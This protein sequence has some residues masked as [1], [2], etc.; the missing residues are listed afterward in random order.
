MG[1]SIISLAGGNKLALGALA[2]REDAV[3]QSGQLP[4][5]DLQ[6]VVDPLFVEAQSADGVRGQP[7]VDQLVGG[8]GAVPQLSVQ[9]RSSTLDA[10]LEVERLVE[11]LA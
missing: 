4:L 6:A 1:E 7:E 10:R 11:P 2:G 3:H 8:Q 9:P 5:R